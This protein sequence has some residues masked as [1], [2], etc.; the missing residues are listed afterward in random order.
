MSEV[1]KLNHQQ[2]MEILPHREPMLLIDEV[3]E[4]LPGDHI[5]AT[6]WVDPALDIFKGHFPDAPV[7]PGVYTVEAT[8]QATD[9]VLMTTPVYV[10]K[11]P[12]FLGI[13]HVKFLK[14]ILPGDTLDIRAE[15]LRERPE[16]AIATCKCVVYT[17][18]DLAAESEITI[19][20]R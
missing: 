12:L 9:L 11:V 3:Q 8:A 19:A 1:K 20:M 6:F 16:K 2:V 10:G 17:S 13:D 7:L 18:G 4:L 14:K 15:I 5:A